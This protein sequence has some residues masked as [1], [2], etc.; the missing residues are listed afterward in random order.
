MPIRSSLV[1]F[2]LQLN[3]MLEINIHSPSQI[4]HTNNS[5]SHLDSKSFRFSASTNVSIHS[6][7]AV[8]LCSLGDFS[9]YEKEL[10]WDE[11]QFILR[12]YSIP[13]TMCLGVGMYFILT[14]SKS[15]CHFLSLLRKA[16]EPIT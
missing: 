9:N 14:Y 7:I 8:F 12:T 15:F 5:I 6:P 3:N 10:L 2:M 13:P 16:A 4:K 11:L 1:V